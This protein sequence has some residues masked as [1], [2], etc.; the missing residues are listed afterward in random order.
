MC[1]CGVFAH[2]EGECQGLAEELEEARKA[3]AEAERER[4]EQASRCE[5]LAAQ[6][7]DMTAARDALAY[8]VDLL[9]HS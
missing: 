1:R 7:A 2:Y 9:M 4:N 6:L 3:G 8:A 5:D